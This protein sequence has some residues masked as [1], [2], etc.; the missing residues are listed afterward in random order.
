[1]HF[2]DSPEQAL[3]VIPLFSDILPRGGAT[4]I[5]PEGLN[6]VARYLVEHPEGVYPTGLSFTS[7]TGLD[8]PEQK[9]SFIDLAKNK[10]TKFVELTG[11]TGDVILLHP[12]MLHS[13]SKN[14]IRA[15]RIITNP[16]VGLKPEFPFRFCREDGSEYSLVEKKTLK[17]LGVD[18]LDWEITAERKRIV[19]K[20][21][22]RQAILMG[23]ERKRL[24]EHYGNGNVV[25]TAVPSVPSAVPSQA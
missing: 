9:Y 4:F 3:L 17:A 6:H 14:Y 7:A 24:E 11:E 23:L 18:K 15:H 16:P 25:P 22:E 19:P 12:L 2:L 1:V 21:V 10:L 13:A 20:R 8:D 5:S